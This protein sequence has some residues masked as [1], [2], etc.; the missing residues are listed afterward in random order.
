MLYR[1]LQR[2]LNRVGET[3]KPCSSDV[4]YC[5]KSLQ[6]LP[7]WVFFHA[8]RKLH[9]FITLRLPVANLKLGVVCH[10]GTAQYYYHQCLS[11]DLAYKHTF[12]DKGETIDIFRTL[13]LSPYLSLNVCLQHSSKSRTSLVCDGFSNLREWRHSKAEERKEDGICPCIILTTVNNSR[14]VVAVLYLAHRVPPTPLAVEQPV[15][16]G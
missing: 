10:Q 14:K 3:T 9:T 4:K 2:A 1:P 11:L 6:N 5:G 15:S 7:H 8:G 12:L 16:S 13:V